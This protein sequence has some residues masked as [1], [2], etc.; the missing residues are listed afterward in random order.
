LDLDELIADDDEPA[1]AAITIA[2]LGV[3]VDTATGKRRQARKAFLDDI[4]E[5]LPVISYDI[6]VARTHTQLLVAV[7]KAGRP[8]GAHDLIIAATALA[9]GRVVVTSDGPGFNDLP[10]I[11]VR[12]PSR[13]L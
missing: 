1:V 3:S 7:R 9:T 12:R 6:E 5:T 13:F 11:P 2:E 8:R 4:V 10:G